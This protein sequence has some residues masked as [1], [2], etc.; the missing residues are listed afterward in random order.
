MVMNGVGREIILV[1]RNAERAEAEAF[2]ISH[3][4]PFAYPLRVKEGDY[5]DLKGSRMVI[6][7]A[8]VSQQKG[9][10]RLDLLKRNAEVFGYVIPKVL[11]NASEAVLVVATNPLDIM[12]YMALHFAKKHGLPESRV[13]GTGTMLDTARFRTLLGG[14]LGIDSQH[15]HAYV[16]GE[17]GDSEVLTWSLASAGAIRLTEYCRQQKIEISEKL[18][19]EIDQRV[20]KAA[21]RIIKGK[22]ATYYGIGSALAKIA[23]VILHDQRSILTVSS[24]TPGLIKGS[25]LCLS[26]PR[27]VGGSGIITD[28]PIRLNERERDGLEKSAQVIKKAINEIKEYL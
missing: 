3:A 9:E 12:T 19:N 8:G 5:Q 16:V 7:S 1:D 10:S 21:Y 24:F 17:H 13:L 26:M 15:V 4:I 6:I 25:N 22:G 18:I 28:I 23:D 20:R 14:H 2:D 27:L 11:E